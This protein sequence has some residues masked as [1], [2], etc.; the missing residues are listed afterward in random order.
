[1]VPYFCGEKKIITRFQSLDEQSNSLFIDEQSL[2]HLTLPA[3]SV[4]TQF[5]AVNKPLNS[6]NQ[7]SRA[8]YKISFKKTRQISLK[9]RII[10]L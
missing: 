3:S 8:L 10:S 5:I 7:N 6:N 2:T 4:F 1:M 9:R